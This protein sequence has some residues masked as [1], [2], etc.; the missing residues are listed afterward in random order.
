M[1]LADFSDLGHARRARIGAGDRHRSWFSGSDARNRSKGFDAP[2]RDD[3]PRRGA[4][5]AD[6]ARIAMK[7]P[8]EW[9][10]RIGVYGRWGAGKT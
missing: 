10:V 4:F 2:T 1:V 6:V 9:S 3:A 5:V 7:S 8:Q